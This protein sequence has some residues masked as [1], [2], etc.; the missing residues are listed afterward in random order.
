MNH[1]PE[2]HSVLVLDN[3]RIHHTDI[4]REIL[5]DSGKWPVRSLTALC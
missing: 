1:Y 4:L 2:K 3:C 5:D